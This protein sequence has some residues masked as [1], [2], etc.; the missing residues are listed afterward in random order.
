MTT[1]CTF[2]HLFLMS[3]SVVKV[4]KYLTTF[5]F[6]FS[7]PREIEYVYESTTTSNTKSQISDVVLRKMKLQGFSISGRFCNSEL[8]E[9]KITL[10]ITSVPKYCIENDYSVRYL[11]KGN[12]LYILFDENDKDYENNLIDLQIH[13]KM[14]SFNDFEE[15]PITLTFERLTDKSKKNSLY[16]L[17]MITIYCAKNMNII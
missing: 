15:L 13:L 7:N 8:H 6:T 9:L 12:K 1:I 3:Y 16:R 11:P 2:S 17:I 10:P 5:L 4:N 14:T